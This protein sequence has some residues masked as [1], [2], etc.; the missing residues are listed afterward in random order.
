MQLSK[1]GTRLIPDS[2][3]WGIR[4]GVLAL[5]EGSAVVLRYLDQNNY[6]RGDLG[7]LRRASREWLAGSVNIPVGESRTLLICLTVL[8]KLDGGH[9]NFIR[10]G[11]LRD[12]PVSRCPELG[13]LPPQ[14]LLAM[15]GGTTQ[16]ATAMYLAG[17]RRKV[18][19]PDPKLAMTYEAVDEW[20]ARRSM[21]LR[22]E[23]RKD[24]VLLAQ[25]EAYVR[26][27][28]TGKMEFEPKEAED[29]C[30]ARMFG[31]MTDGEGAKR[32]PKLALH[33]SDR[34]RSVS[35]AWGQVTRELGVD[36]TDHRV[37]QAAAMFAKA[38]SLEAKFYHPTAVDKSWPLFWDWLD[39]THAQSTV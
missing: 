25:A 12:R 1:V 3:S 14:K 31:L 8:D 28:R 13:E 29:F 16:W 2:K 38:H 7:A 11:T 4:G 9:R 23:T 18:Q 37:V 39:S 32:W 35:V 15:D 17:D 21:Q 22:W 19:N 10:E 36:S 26:F 27:L 34:L 33:E 24:S 20:R 6:V 5:R 30:F